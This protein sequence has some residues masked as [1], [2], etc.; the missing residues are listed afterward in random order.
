[1]SGRK[2]FKI[3][4]E[5]YVDV[6]I[7]WSRCVISQKDTSEKTI[8]VAKTVK[9]EEER[10]ERFR[11]LLQNIRRFKEYTEIDPSLQNR[12]DIQGIENKCCLENSVYHKTC[13]NKYDDYHFGRLTGKR[14]KVVEETNEPTHSSV[15][16]YAIYVQGS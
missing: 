14:K 3:F 9:R 1:M 13:K 4:R 6:T 7:N 8:N 2:S 5:D 11:N 15:V 10:E 12:L 16:K